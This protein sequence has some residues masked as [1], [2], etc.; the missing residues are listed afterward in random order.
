MTNERKNFISKLYK[1]VFGTN[2]R[3]RFIVGVAS[4]SI[5][6]VGIRLVAYQTDPND[7]VL[8]IDQQSD[9]KIILAGK[10]RNDYIERRNADGT[11]DPTFST[12]WMVGGF[13]GPVHAFAVEKSNDPN[14]NDRIV[15][16]GQFTNFDDAVVGYIARLQKDGKLDREFANNIGT[17]FD[18]IVRTVRIQASGKIVVGGEFEYFNGSYVKYLA[19]LNSD[20][21]LDTSFNQGEGFDLPVIALDSLPNEQ[22]LVGGDFKFYKG[23]PAAHVLQLENSGEADPSFSL[24]VMN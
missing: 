12:N 8:Q 19:R 22:I 6:I 5:I 7:E 9:G 1:V 20:G 11:M 2:H 15:A 4:L 16:V 21:T 17:G 13:N 10:F 18:N 24:K 3:I 23:N 14:N